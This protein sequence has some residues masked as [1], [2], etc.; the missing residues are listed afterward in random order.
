M[1]IDLD[2]YWNARLILS[3]VE[4]SGPNLGCGRFLSHAPRRH[5]RSARSGRRT[6][7]PIAGSRAPPL[8]LLRHERADDHPPSIAHP[9]AE[10]ER[11]SCSTPSDSRNLLVHG[12][13]CPGLR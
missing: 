3:E 5:S 13:H 4:G 6:T 7:C 11:M 1:L 10:G 9:G 2:V 8:V 12:T